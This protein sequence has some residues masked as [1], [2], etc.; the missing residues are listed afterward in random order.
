[1]LTASEVLTKLDSLK[2]A[3]TKA[4]SA[5]AVAESQFKQAQDMVTKAE[6]ALRALGVDPAKAE[7]QLGQELVTLNQEIDRVS[8]ELQAKL[9]EYAAIGEAFRKVGA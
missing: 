3:H 4:V 2:A 1:M 5:H 6:D 8:A 9:S 7:S